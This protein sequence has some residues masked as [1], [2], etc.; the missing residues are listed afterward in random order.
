M[1]ISKEE[2]ALMNDIL[3]KLVERTEMLTERVQN[4]EKE[5][6]EHMKALRQAPY[7]LKK[8]GT[9][10]KKPGRKGVML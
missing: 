9:P 4:L 6:Y 2:K 5:S 7:G 10:C 1:F 3:N 8:D